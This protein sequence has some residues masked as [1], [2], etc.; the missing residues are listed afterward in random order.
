MDQPRLPALGPEDVGPEV[1][2]IFERCLG[3]E[4]VAE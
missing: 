2:A 4:E 1:R 3:A